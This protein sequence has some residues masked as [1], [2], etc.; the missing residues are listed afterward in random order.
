MPFRIK[1][2]LSFANRA[3]EWGLDLPT[4]SNGSA[5]G[6]LDND[7]DLDLILNNVNMP[8]LVYE[9]KSKQL[10]PE[11]ATLSFVLHGENENS[12]ALGSKIRL[13]IKGRLI[14]QE[15]S[16]M[17]GFMSTVDSRIHVGLGR[18]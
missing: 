4:H 1:E 3:G 2:I 13:K 6:D 18:C 8:S 7:G 11:N 17:R 5:Y 15:L 12:F 16:P 9:N 14:Y 10:T